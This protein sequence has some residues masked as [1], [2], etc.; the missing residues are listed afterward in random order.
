MNAN[1]PL[2]LAE[3][4]IEPGLLGRVVVCPAC[5]KKIKI[6]IPI[7][8]PDVPTHNSTYSRQKSEVIVTGISIPFGDLVT[9]LIKTA[10]AMIPAAI[11]LGL[12]GMAL[13]AVFMAFMKH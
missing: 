9:L 2:C 10:L 4:E 5:E 13:I 11:I 7:S 3:I 12:F 8:S 1:C 6:P